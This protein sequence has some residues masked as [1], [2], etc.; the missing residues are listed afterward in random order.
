MAIKW[1]KC[2]QF[3][4]FFIFLCV[5]STENLNQ[6]DL[7]WLY[8]SID[9]SISDVINHNLIIIINIDI[10]SIIAIDIYFYAVY[11]YVYFR[12]YFS[13]ASNLIRV[14]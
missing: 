10:I 13:I 8:T 3:A 4:I 7:E 12:K 14:A 11:S 6:H 1:Y 5:T 9:N 2:L